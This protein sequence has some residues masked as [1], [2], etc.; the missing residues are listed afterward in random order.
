LF[1]GQAALERIVL[2]ERVDTTAQSG[3]LSEIIPSWAIR[4]R[5]L[6]RI[7]RI[8]PSTVLGVT[9]RSRAISSRE[10]CVPQDKICRANTDFF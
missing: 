2:A 9:P 6:S 7:M 8:L 10:H 1:R 4:V 5:N 3:R